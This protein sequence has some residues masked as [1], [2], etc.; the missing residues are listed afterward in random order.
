MTYS[1]L[2][3]TV[4]F[5]EANLSNDVKNNLNMLNFLGSVVLSVYILFVIQNDTRHG[6][7]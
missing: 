3:I 1:N 6:H 7:C 4:D 2:N 5:F